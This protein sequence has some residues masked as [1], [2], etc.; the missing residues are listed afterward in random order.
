[1]RKPGLNN[2]NA[3]HHLEE[4]AQESTSLQIKS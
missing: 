1:M 3:M 2:E 4:K